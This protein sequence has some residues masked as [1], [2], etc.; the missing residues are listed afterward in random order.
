MAKKL[1]LLFS[2]LK[3]L[4]RSYWRL[5]FGGADRGCRHG[6]ISADERNKAHR[7]VCFWIDNL[8]F[9]NFFIET[10]KNFTMQIFSS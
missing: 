10:T 1:S 6:E 5:M 4:P 8:D 2:D 9:K 3:V 7:H